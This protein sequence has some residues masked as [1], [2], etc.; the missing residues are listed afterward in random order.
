MSVYTAT[1]LATKITEAKAAIEAA[2]LGKEYS[3]NTGQSIIRVERQTL[4]DL[5]KY[6]KYLEGEL[7]ALNSGNLQYMDQIG[8]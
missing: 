8:Y 1:E 4:P 7:I 2:L 6:L 5:Q 3:L